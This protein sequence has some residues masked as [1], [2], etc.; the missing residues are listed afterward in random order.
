MGRGAADMKGFLALAINRM[1]RADPDALR[2][3]LALLL[4]YDE[5]IGTLGARRFSEQRPDAGDPARR[6]HR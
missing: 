6:D 5:E 3:P 4:T 1:A 2:R